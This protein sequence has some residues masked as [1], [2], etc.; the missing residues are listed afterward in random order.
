MA[1]GSSNTLIIVVIVGLIGIVLFGCQLGLSFICGI[2]GKRPGQGGMGGG[3][4]GTPGGAVDLSTLSTAEVAA[5]Q[6]ELGV[7]EFPRV[8]AAEAM[9]FIANSIVTDIDRSTYTQLHRNEI[10]E[11]KANLFSFYKTDLLEIAEMNDMR[12]QPLEGRALSLYS[13]LLLEVARDNGISLAPGEES[14]FETNL[15]AGSPSPS[16]QITAQRSVI[17]S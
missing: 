17:I 12:L 4:L 3:I 7:E 2:T 6:Q 16:Q 10:F 11:L 1:N 15:F 14:A 9:E 5:L 8:T 13:R